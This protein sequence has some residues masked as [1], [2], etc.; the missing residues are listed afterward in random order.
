MIDW[1]GDT[2]LATSLLMALV[3]LVR[4]PVR[5]Q[6]GPAVAYGLW[7]IPILRL[8]MPPLITTVERA[9]PAAAPISFDTLRSA[10]VPAAQPT[11]LEQLGGWQEVAIAAWLTGAAGMLVWGFLMYRWQRREVL[12]DSVQLARL[13]KIRLVQS[14][15]VRGP[16][17]FGIFDRVI[18]LPIDFEERFD[19]GERRLAFDHELSHH[20][21][22]A[23][24]LA[25][26]PSPCSACSGSTR[27]PGFPIPRSASTRRRLAMHGCWTERATT[28]APPMR[29]QSPRQPRDG[30]C[31][32]PAPSTVRAHCTGDWHPCSLRQA[33]AAALPAAPSSP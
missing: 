25:I 8:M 13:D 10:V 21:A 9:A 26:S 29:A 17:A 31:Y 5:R 16:M 22:G 7:I 28:I 20:H 24:S 1:L 19:P 32:L 23:S 6:F 18:A 30:R 3:L 2:L 11:L 27:W 33:A 14:P 15:A 12:R 4:E